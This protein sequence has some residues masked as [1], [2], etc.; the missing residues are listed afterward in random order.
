MTGPPSF[1]L[2]ESDPAV[3]LIFFAIVIGFW[4]VGAIIKSV[5]HVA[6]QQKLQERMRTVNR[7]APARQ[8]QLAPEIARRLPPVM[9]ARPQPPARQ[10]KLKAKAKRPARQVS[11]PAPVAVPQVPSGAV[12]TNVFAEKREPTASLPQSQALL[13]GRLLQPDT[14]R[15]QF[16]LMEILQPPLALRERS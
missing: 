16:V 13:I 8:P 1:I 12:A 3:K 7:G 2:A 9:P 15:Q 11:Q 4:I 10:A 14:L 6:E 5:K